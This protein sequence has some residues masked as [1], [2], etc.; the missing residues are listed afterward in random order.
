MGNTMAKP[1]PWIASALRKIMPSDH[2]DVVK[3]Q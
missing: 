1:M 3:A 2:A